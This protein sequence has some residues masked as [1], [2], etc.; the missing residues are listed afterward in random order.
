MQVPVEERLAASL[1]PFDLH[2]FGEKKIV[3]AMHE[4]GIRELRDAQKTHLLACISDLPNSLLRG[5][6]ATGKSTTVGIV[7]LRAVRP[8][9][10]QPEVHAVVL[11]PSNE[12]AQK[13]SGRASPSVHSTAFS[14]NRCSR[15]SAST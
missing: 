11:V 6:P 5:P 15:R 10:Q 8:V 1:P 9:Q 2:R 14:S 4:A 12:R 7:L 3:R 13:V